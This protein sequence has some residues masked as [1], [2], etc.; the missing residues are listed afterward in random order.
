MSGEPPYLGQNCVTPFSRRELVL[1]TLW[2]VVQA[3]LFRW[4]PRPWHGFRAR[5]LQLWGADIPA[6]SQVVVFPTAKIFFPWKLHLAPR[7]MIGR[8]VIIYNLAP[9][10]LAYGANLSQRVHL[11]AGSHDFLRWSMPLTTAP[12]VIG[13]NAWIAAEVFVGPGVT[14]GELAVIGARSVVVKDQP[15]RM[16]CAGHPCRPLKPRPEPQ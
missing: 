5:L 8:E 6:P 10:T 16:I 1:R 11:C 4:S 14:I 7:S 12:I 9:V 3:T 2:T 15:P 13:I